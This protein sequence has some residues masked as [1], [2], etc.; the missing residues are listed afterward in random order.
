MSEI[1]PAELGAAP[2]PAPWQTPDLYWDELKVGDHAVSPGRTVSEADVV[3]FA[4]LSGDFNQLHIDATYAAGRGFGRRVVY[5]LLGQAIGSGLF[6]RTWLGV[7]TQKHM[8]A[9]TEIQWHFRAPIFI[10][11]TLHTAVEVIELRPTSKPERGLVRLKRTILNQDGVVAQ[12]GFS[13]FLMD[14]RP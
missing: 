13:V 1:D 14:R 6:T 2:D 3:N 11:D 8:V 7:G 12:E 9:M 4:G 5:G 10:G